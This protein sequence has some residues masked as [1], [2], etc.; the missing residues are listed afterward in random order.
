MKYWIKAYPEIIE[1]NLDYFNLPVFTA[2][3]AMTGKVESCAC[4]FSEKKYAVIDADF[5]DFNFSDVDY[6]FSQLTKSYPSINKFIINIPYSENNI[7]AL[8]IFN[9]YNNNSF[10][11][12]MTIDAN[13]KAVAK[14][15]IILETGVDFFILKVE[16]TDYLNNYKIIQKLRDM[17]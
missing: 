13:Y 8:K 9:A 14:S 1:K 2:F 11:F 16:K 7:V 15:N 6:Y 10:K 5:S 3:K 12:A 4:L 17:I